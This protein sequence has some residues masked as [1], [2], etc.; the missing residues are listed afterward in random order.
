[1]FAIIFKDCMFPSVIYPSLIF[2]QLIIIIIY[3]VF[4]HSHNSTGMN[5]VIFRQKL[6]ALETV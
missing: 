4:H 2:L 5:S 3:D 1:M 6:N